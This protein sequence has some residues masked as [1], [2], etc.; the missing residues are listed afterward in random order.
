MRTARLRLH[1]FYKSV[2]GDSVGVVGCGR[3]SRHQDALERERIYP[4]VGAYVEMILCCDQRLEMV[5]S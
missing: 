5:K 2:E 1:H 3:R 4:S